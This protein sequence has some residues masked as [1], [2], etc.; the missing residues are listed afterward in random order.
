M[1]KWICCYKPEIRHFDCTILGSSSFWVGFP[2]NSGND[3]LASEQYVNCQ[4]ARQPYI[5]SNFLE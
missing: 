3:N 2:I 1:Y 4:V 5:F